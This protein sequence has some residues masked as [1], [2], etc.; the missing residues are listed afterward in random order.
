MSKIIFVFLSF[1]VFFE[2]SME[3]KQVVA[4]CETPVPREGASIP[5]PIRDGMSFCSPDGPVVLKDHV[6]G[7]P[8]S[9]LGLPYTT[10]WLVIGSLEVV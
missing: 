9:S 6:V 3:S 8:L 10:V 4:P 1:H 7:D 2:I 5:V